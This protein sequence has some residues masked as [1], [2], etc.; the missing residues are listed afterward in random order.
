MTNSI[1]SSINYK[2]M[3]MAHDLAHETAAGIFSENARDD[4]YE[5]LDLIQ[6]LKDLYLDVVVDICDSRGIEYEWNDSA[7]DI[8]GRIP[9]G[10][11]LIGM[12]TDHF[13][14]ITRR[15]YGA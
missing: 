5:L 11:D 12:A 7:L 9:A 8:T 4:A 14:D 1:N 2:L 10:L 13:I 6:E 15:E 3:D